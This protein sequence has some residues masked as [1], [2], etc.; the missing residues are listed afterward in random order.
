MALASGNRVSKLAA[1]DK[2][3]VTFNN[4]HSRVTMAV[5]P[6]LVFKNQSF[7]RS[8]PS[9]S[10]MALK[11]PKSLCPVCALASYLDHREMDQHAARVFLNP[12]TG[13]A[14][15]SA[16]VALWLCRAI[17]ALVPGALP[18]AHDVQKF[19]FP[20]A[21]ARGVPVEEIVKKGFLVL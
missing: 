18:R 21:W 15:N 11:A 6:G 1:L 8:Q 3:S 20:L 19:S 16:S 13:A 2:A 5:R 10:F 7:S 12:E 14:L 4:D 17:K 9:I